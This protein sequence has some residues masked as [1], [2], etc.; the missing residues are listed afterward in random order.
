MQKI[1][2]IIGA[3]PQFIKASVVS[4]AIQQTADIEEIIL[5]TGQ[6]FDSNMSDV[7]FNQLG[8]PK[9]DIQLDI[10]G[11]SHGKMT[12]RMLAE[13]EQALLTHKPD[14]VLVYGDTNSTLAGALAAAKLHIPV[15]HIEAGL[16]SFN[17]QMPEEIN[18][19]L[20]DQISDLLFCP[21]NTAVA[22]LKNEGFTDKPVKILQVGDV[23]QDAAI[24]FAEKAQAPHGTLPDSFILATLHRAENTDNPER[25]AAVVTALNEVNATIAPVVLPLHPRT[26]RL[27][28]EQGLELSVHLVDPVGYFEMVWLLDHCQLVLTDS[29]GVQK[30]AFFFGKACVTMRDQTEWVELIEAGANELVGASQSKI[31]NA[32]KRHYGRYVED[33]ETLYGGG[34]ASQKIVQTLATNT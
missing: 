13:I 28:A 14:R 30:E 27:I 34:L 10:H 20:T 5:H 9:P 6:H 12:G 29:G 3:R 23:M 4:R 21:T 22:N 32:T 16:R 26:R 17:M 1:L 31:I 11:G 2:T 24:L 25:L 18:R 15:A 19:I 8:I 7:F 33:T